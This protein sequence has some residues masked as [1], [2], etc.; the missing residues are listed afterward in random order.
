MTSSSS[1]ATVDRGLDTMVLV[2]AL[3]DGHPASTTGGQLLRAHGGWFVTSLAL[4][5]A[6]AILTKVYGVTPALA[7]SKIEQFANAVAA[8]G[9]ADSL[10]VDLNDA[11]LLQAA[12]QHGVKWIATEDGRLAKVCGPIGITAHAP[13]SPTVRQQV[14]AWENANL[15]GTGLA[16]VLRPV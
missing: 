12:A 2:Y 8:L 7:S 5:E 4:L 16:R 9:L 11:V 14:T 15:S 10:G 3:L 6:K 1:P 13:L